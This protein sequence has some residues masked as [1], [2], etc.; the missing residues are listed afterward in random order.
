M[1][2]REVKGAALTYQELD[3]NF[4]ELEG[5]ITD[6]TVRE[7]AL[8]SIS[9]A[10]VVDL[11]VGPFVTGTLTAATSLTFTNP[12]SSGVLKPFVLSFSGVFPITFP[13]GTRFAGGEELSITGPNYDINCLINSSGVVT[14]YGVVDTIT[15]LP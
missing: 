5:K 3:N 8:G 1:I 11:A 13:V 4:T 9:G 14:V 7:N 2:L 15:T 12:P 6:L 10:V